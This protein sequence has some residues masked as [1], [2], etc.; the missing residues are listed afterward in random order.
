MMKSVSLFVFALLLIVN[1]ST[2]WGQ[3]SEEN[4]NVNYSYSPKWWQTNISLPESNRKVLVGKGGQLMYEYPVSTSESKFSQGSGFST[5]IS[6]TYG[7]NSS[8]KGQNLYKPEVPVVITEK[9]AKG[10][11]ITEESFA[12]TPLLFGANDNTIQD[13]LGTA[14]NRKITDK[15]GND[16]VLVTLENKGNGA[17]TCSPELQINSTY[18]VMVDTA[19]GKAYISDFL[20]LTIPYAIA[21]TSVQPA[22]KNN[23]E[24]SR[25][26]T[27]LTLKPIQIEAGQKIQLAVGV[28]Q[29]FTAI[30]CP[31]NLQQALLLKKQSIAWWENLNLPYN[32]ITVPDK[33]IQNLFNA[34]IRNIYQNAESEKELLALNTGASSNRQVYFSDA[35]FIIE[36][37]TMLNQTSDA[38]RA[39]D[40]LFSLQK[41]D[42]SFLQQD[43]DWKAT[44]FVLWT[45]TNHARLT[46]DKQWLESV[47]PKLEKGYNFLIDLQK[48]TLQKGKVPYA[49]MLPPGNGGEGQ[50][51]DYV[52]N[53]W[54]LSG[55][56][57]LINAARWVGRNGQAIKW[58]SQYDIFYKAFQEATKKSMKKD[59]A[60]N[61]YLPVRAITD[62]NT[63]PQKS[64]W[65]FLNAVYPG[66]ILDVNDPI[67]TGN[68]KMLERAV[69][70]GMLYNTGWMNNGIV[71]ATGSDYAH[72]LQWTGKAQES[73]KVMYAVANHAAPNY[74]W[75]EQQQ[76]K[77]A[78]D[79]MVA[80]DMPNS[81]VAA[82]FIRM[83]RHMIVN[84]RYYELHLLEGVPSSWTK[85]GM[86][87]KLDNIQTEF[88][89]LT[90]GLKFSE[91]GTKATL[92]M[93]LDSN[94][95]RAPQKTLLHLDGISGNPAVVELELKPNMQKILT[96][97]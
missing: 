33:E 9:E 20:R 79:T 49:G 87:I 86:E 69:K 77:E 76:L 26:I 88:G 60:G 90:F 56:N 53:Y 55:L 54:A 57:S 83:V 11:V 19:K 71:L 15:P 40:N 7:D 94:N 8:W 28:S 95:R 52:N 14:L 32:K 31:N 63:A 30:D 67:I 48:S 81:R 44:G 64:Q 29:G 45:A 85:P 93:N 97:N 17:I 25:N 46:G 4:L 72:A 62:K 78:A 10:L 75:Y 6:L 12:V 51:I 22:K 96:L 61:S 92:T 3:K 43:K 38:R 58:Q 16:I 65:A 36:A 5:L 27:T 89:L 39:L 34:S 59:A 70:E 73:V 74:S 68:M 23:G 13:Y 37:L 82:E 91:D 2:L 84:E 35:P 24:K 18:N 47:W 1:T 41:S 66:R 80:G 42:G 50:G 21:A